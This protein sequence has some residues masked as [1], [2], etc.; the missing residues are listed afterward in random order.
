[1]LSFCLKGEFRPEELNVKVEGRMLIVK[2]DRQIKVGN[3]TESKQF[4]RELTLPEFVDVKSLQSYLA[5]D[6]TLT[7]EAP[8]LLDRV[9][10][11]PQLTSSSNY[12]SAS[13]NRFLDSGVTG[14][15]QSSSNYNTYG[16]NPSN[17]YSSTSSA[18]SFRQEG[19]SLRDSHPAR[20]TS[21]SRDQYSSTTSSTSTLIGGT[22]FNN[23]PAPTTFS[24]LT[25]RPDYSTV[26]RYDSSK[27]VTHK[28]NLSEFAP[29]DIAIQVNDTMLKITALKQERDGRGS[30]HREFRREIGKCN[31]SF[32]D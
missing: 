2:G 27:E 19:P 1:M 13:P 32:E 21:P 5:D 28:F 20:R 29:E 11:Q 18:S 30:T 16:N 3:A 14:G 4:N 15:R 17:S 8:V 23:N 6:G 24:T 7:M 25:S 22:G 26:D 9:Y 10:N 12:R 31:R